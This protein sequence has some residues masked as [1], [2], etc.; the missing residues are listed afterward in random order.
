MESF[1]TPCDICRLP[2]SIHH[3]IGEGFLCDRCFQDVENKECVAE[4]MHKRIDHPVFGDLWF[5]YSLSLCIKYLSA[6]L[7]PTGKPAMARLRAR[8]WGIKGP[9]CNVCMMSPGNPMCQ[10]RDRLTT[11]EQNYI[12]LHHPSVQIICYDCLQEIFDERHTRWWQEVFRDH[13]ILVDS[14]IQSRISKYLWFSMHDTLCLCGNCDPFWLSRE[15]RRWGCPMDVDAPG[16]SIIRKIEA[17][18]TVT[19]LAAACKLC[20]K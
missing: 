12:R 16:E 19:D 20:A 2:P 8:N 17:A 10:I 13:S 7:F 4:L 14:A 11:P 6:Y 1:G 5:I 9:T 18:T 15:G 3:P